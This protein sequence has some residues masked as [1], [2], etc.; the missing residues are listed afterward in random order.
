MSNCNGKCGSCKSGGAIATPR[1]VNRNT[2]TEDIKDF[3][4]PPQKQKEDGSSLENGC[5]HYHFGSIERWQCD[6]CIVEWVAAHDDES[7]RKAIDFFKADNKSVTAERLKDAL[8]EK[9]WKRKIED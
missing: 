4:K 1:S 9:I 2:N 7:V 5:G 8:K 3:L 6:I